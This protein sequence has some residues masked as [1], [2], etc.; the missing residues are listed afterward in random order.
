M[1]FPANLQTI[2]LPSL[3]AEPKEA[4][5]VAIMLTKKERK[6]MRTQRRREA[7]SEKQEKIRLGLEPPPPPKGVQAPPPHTHTHFPKF[8]CIGRLFNSLAWVN[9]MHI[10]DDLRLEVA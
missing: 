9:R 5:P 4:A 6:K 3:S 1:V 2:C 10:R 7:E 8:V